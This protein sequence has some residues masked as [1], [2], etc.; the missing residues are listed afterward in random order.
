MR[1]YMIRHGQSE[2]NVLGLF[3]GHSGYPLSEL[4]HRQAA[5]TLQA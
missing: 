2:G 4:G 3:T 1:M 5:R